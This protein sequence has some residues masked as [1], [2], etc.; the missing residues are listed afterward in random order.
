MGGQLVNEHPHP[1]FI[2][3]DAPVL[4]RLVEG[5]RNDEDLVGRARYGKVVLAQGV[6]TEVADHRT[7]RRRDHHRRK[8]REHRSEQGRERV[9]GMGLDR[10]VPADR[11]TEPFEERAVGLN[12]LG[13]P[14]GAGDGLDPRLAAH[15][16]RRGDTRNLGEIEQ[17]HPGQVFDGQAYL[18][19]DVGL[20]L[21]LGRHGL[22]DLRCLLPGVG[23][24]E[25]PEQF[26]QVAE[27]KVASTEWIGTG[28]KGIVER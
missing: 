16:G 9:V 10:G 14:L 11:L 21:A 20:A 22:G 18:G 19:L 1:E 4:R 2:D 27:G 28:H 3:R 7:G 5:R 25:R 23:V 8:I 13:G 17:S 24:A 15:G 6:L 12:R 26:A